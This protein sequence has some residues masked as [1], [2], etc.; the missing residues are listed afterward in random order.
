MPFIYSSRPIDGKACKS[1]VFVSFVTFADPQLLFFVVYDSES[2]KQ[3]L[4]EGYTLVID[5]Y[6]AS[7]IAFSVAKVHSHSI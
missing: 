6:I 7:G 5:R 1:T 3:W 2:M 4:Q